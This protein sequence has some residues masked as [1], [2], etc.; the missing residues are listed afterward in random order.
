MKFCWQEYCCGSG[1]TL[2]AM[3]RAATESAT[4]SGVPPPGD[5]EYTA[6]NQAHFCGDVQEVAVAVDVLKS[7]I[8]R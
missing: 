4:L 2:P 8:A 7:L 1:P 5:C 6:L 3:L